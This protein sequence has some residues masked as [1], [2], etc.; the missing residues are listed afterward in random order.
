M[1]RGKQNKTQGSQDDSRNGSQDQVPSTSSCLSTPAEAVEPPAHGEGS[2]VRG[3]VSQVF[4]PS[5]AD[6]H[7]VFRRA[8]QEPSSLSTDDLK[9]LS[10]AICQSAIRRVNYAIPAAEFCLAIIEAEGCETFLESLLL[11]CRELFNSR[12]E[13]LRPPDQPTVRS[14]RW[15]AYVTFLAELLDGLS[16]GLGENTLRPCHGGAAS[17]AKA[18]SM[19]VLATLLCVSCHTILQPPSLYNPTEMDCLRT[20]L[21]TAGAALERVA[22]ERLASLLRE[23]HATLEMQG[24]PIRSRHVLLELKELQAA[25]WQLSPAQQPSLSSGTGR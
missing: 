11:F 2:H 13:V 21:T 7:N 10:V 5:A 6:C 17:T 15:V 1:E 23:I 18:R 14:R 20:A 16:E 4:V 22:P 24:L 8:M 25:G 12:D 9:L 19:M 3:A